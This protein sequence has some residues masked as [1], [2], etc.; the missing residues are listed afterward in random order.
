M[1]F[2]YCVFWVDIKLTDRTTA[3]SPTKRGHIPAVDTDQVSTGTPCGPHCWV[4]KAPLTKLS[5]GDQKR[6]RRDVI[7]V[8]LHQFLF[9]MEVLSTALFFASFPD[10]PGIW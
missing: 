1:G 10:T 8:S 3:V 6:Y 9:L 2:Q 5:H 7:S 4:R